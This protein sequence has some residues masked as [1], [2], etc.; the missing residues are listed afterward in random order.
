[1]CS[2]NHL[3]VIKNGCWKGIHRRQWV[4]IIYTNRSIT[5]IR[6]N[7]QH[8][9]LYWNCWRVERNHTENINPLYTWICNDSAM[10]DHVTKECD[11]ATRVESWCDDLAMPW[12]NVLSHQKQLGL[13]F[14]PGV[15]KYVD[16]VAVSDNFSAIRESAASLSLPI[17]EWLTRVW[18]QS[19]RRLFKR[20]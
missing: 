14:W 9:F 3:S 11:D 7:I 17:S 8:I 1:M 10:L 18:A 19:T 16:G 20:S 4:P 12:W 6:L 13:Y 5:P 2:T 15:N